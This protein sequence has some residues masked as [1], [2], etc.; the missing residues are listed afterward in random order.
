TAPAQAGTSE[1]QPHGAT[2]GALE[3][4]PASVDALL[5]EILDAEVTGHLVTVDA[6][7]ER[8][9]AGHADVSE[10]LLRALHTMNGAFAMTEL[11]TV[12]QALTPAEGYVR[13]LLA[14][15]TPASGE[16]IAAIG[17][18]AT[19]TRAAIAGLQSSYPQVP[20]AVALAARLLALRDG[21]PEPAPRDPEAMDDE[22]ADVD[23]D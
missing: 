4:V 6:W 20:V 1:E 21:L 16:G 2:A 23:L 19:V 18:L 9:A 15:G 17:E 13:R 11:P 14:A 7:V 3:M 8:A 12:A 10:P 5:L 22:G